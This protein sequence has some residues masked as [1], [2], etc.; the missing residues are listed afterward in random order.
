MD[1]E[2]HYARPDELERVNELRNMVR[3][4]HATA[5]TDMFHKAG[6]DEYIGQVVAEYNSDEFDILVAE[7]NGVIC[8][9]AVVECF[10]KPASLYRMARQIY[11]IVDLGVD[12]NYRRQGVATKLVDTIRKDAIDKGFL[13]VELEM[14]EFNNEAICFF[15]KEGFNTFRRFMEMKLKK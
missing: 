11:R 3:E 5:R 12:E 14:W 10:N 4:I 15:E 8:G 13:R 2:I 9:F 1:I 6:N 7:V